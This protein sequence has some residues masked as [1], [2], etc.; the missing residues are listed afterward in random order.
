M[1]VHNWLIF[2]ECVKHV[3]HKGG[4]TLPALT[5]LIKPSIF[6]RTLQ[7]CGTTDVNWM[8]KPQLAR[9]WNIKQ[10]VSRWLQ[11][12][13][14]A[15]DVTCRV[16]Y[17]VVSVRLWLKGL[18]GFCLGSDCQWGENF[19]MSWG[20]KLRLHFIISLRCCSEFCRCPV[21]KLFL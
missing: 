19:K 11:L 3:G 9:L 2:R 7:T 13:Y 16:S 15:A 21:I 20:D 8:R 12:H 6:H 18:R 4:H 5:A 17:R 1:V 10:A 14:P